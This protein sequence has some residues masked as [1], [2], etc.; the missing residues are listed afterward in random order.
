M[1]V[2]APQNPER[3][4]SCIRTFSESRRSPPTSRGWSDNLKCIQSIANCNCPGRR[5]CTA[6]DKFPVSPRYDAARTEPECA[7]ARRAD[8]LSLALR[9]GN[10]PPAAPRPRRQST[11]D[12]AATLA[13]VSTAGGLRTRSRERPRRRLQPSLALPR[14]APIR[15]ECGRQPTNLITHFRTLHGMRANGSGGRMVTLGNREKV[16]EKSDHEW[17]DG[18]DRGHTDESHEHP[19]AVHHVLH[20]SL[21]WREPS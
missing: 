2:T 9:G 16:F 7:R 1:I 10:G 8:P 4:A 14:A 3:R 21:R 6:C 5:H 11:G 18:H 15:F 17:T 13:A 19:H 20:E 12:R